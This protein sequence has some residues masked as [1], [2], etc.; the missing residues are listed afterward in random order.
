MEYSGNFRIFNKFSWAGNYHNYFCN[1]YL[2]GYREIII[3]NLL[4]PDELLNKGIQRLQ[5]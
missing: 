2:D 5:T 4:I 3:R 1:N